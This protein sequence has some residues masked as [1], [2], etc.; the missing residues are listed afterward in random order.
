MISFKNI[1]KEYKTSGFKLTLDDK[2]LGSNGI[3]ALLGKNG[4]GKSTTIKFLLGLQEPDTG[5]IY[6]NSHNLLKEP[7]IKKR[8]GYVSDVP[9]L[10][11][12]LTGYE[13]LKFIQ[14][15]YG[16]DDRGIIDE[17]LTMFEL[18]EH[19]D[20]KIYGY[21]KGMKQKIAII[22]ALCHNPDIL[23]MDEPFTALDPVSV[24]KLKDC[25]KKWCEKED[26][27]VIISS[28]DL[29]VVEDICTDAW[30]LDNGKIVLYA[31]KEELTAD[32]KTFTS[33]FKEYFMKD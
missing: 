10:Y 11:E 25:L 31:N 9:L 1:S 24:I 20:E 19:K 28:H 6:I 22:S 27:M 32:N 15:L 8:F 13:F 29:D 2:V 16:V 7:D 23:I 21:S 5:E 12:A 4:A 3:H 26:K 18:G 17:Y 14:F 30:Y 33:E